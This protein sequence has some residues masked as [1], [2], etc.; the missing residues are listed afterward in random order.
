MRAYR[1]GVLHVE[2]VDL[3]A[4]ARDFGTPCY[5]YSSA[6]VRSNWRAYDSAFGARPH[7]VLYAV[8]AND[9]LSLLRLL[10]DQ[11]S[12][13]DIVSGGE[14]E[15][16][17]AAGATPSDIVFSGVGKSHAELETAL[18]VGISCINVESAAELT[19]IAQIARR[20]GCRAPVA[21]RVNPDV[22]AATHPYIST[23]LKENKFGIP[24]A[25]AER[26]YRQIA[27]DAALRAVGVASHIGSQLTDAGPVVLAVRELARLATTLECRG[28]TLEHIDVGGGLGIRYRDEEPPAIA[29]FVATVSAEVPAELRILIEPGRSVVGPAGML[30]T[31]VEYLKHTAAKNFAIVDCAMN[32]LLRPA[33]YDAWHAVAPVI[34]PT[35]DAQPLLYDIV[36]PVCESG[37]WLAKDRLLALGQD[38]LLAILDVGAYGYVMTSNYNARP[39]PAEVLVG[40]DSYRLI[41][42]RETGRE[43][44]ASELA[45][46]AR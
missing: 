22:D 8:K 13:F 11:G 33:L 28:I 39:R 1:D 16:V 38:E 29:D 14:L 41:R 3:R 43:L 40:A 18:A 2:N 23:G 10:R 45:L 5:V 7:R 44:M 30:L 25:D 26:L 46:L 6:A 9:N 19:R 31:R 24:L 21:L 27:D 4:I 12:G 34:A 20:L 42:A 35:D 15:R 36:G 17:M 32:D 37:D